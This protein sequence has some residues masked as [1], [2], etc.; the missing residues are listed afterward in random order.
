[1]SAAFTPETLA[2]RPLATAAAAAAATAG[3]GTDGDAAA[4]IA[5]ELS[6]L[7]YM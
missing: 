4:R 3:T 2:A 7:G 5:D 1:M 6:D